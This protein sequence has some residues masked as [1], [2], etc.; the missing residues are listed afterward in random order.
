M[1]IQT[2]RSVVHCPVNPRQHRAACKFAALQ[3]SF[4][5]AWAMALQQRARKGQL[6]FGTAVCC[7]ICT[8][9]DCKK[10]YLSGYA[11][12]I[13]CWLCQLADAFEL[14]Y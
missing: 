4:C 5:F 1:Q 14:A 3:A 12:F 9:H 6:N 11:I 8:M 13:L 7:N 10:R 2:Q